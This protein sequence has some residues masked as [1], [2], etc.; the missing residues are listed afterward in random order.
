MLTLDVRSSTMLSGMA[1]R[2]GVALE[3]RLN[4]ADL[5][6]VG[7]VPGAFS[8]IDLSGGWAILSTRRMSTAEWTSWIVDAVVVGRKRDAT[9]TRLLNELIVLVVARVRSSAVKINSG[10]LQGVG[11]H[12][13]S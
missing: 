3:E 6:D 9:R 2:S 10:R 4:P 7:D 1:A 5:G 13:T 8:L 12:L 11:A